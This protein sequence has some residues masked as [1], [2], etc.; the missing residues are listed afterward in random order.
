MSMTALVSAFC[1]AYHSERDGA[2]IFDDT[3]AAK[4]LT[5]EERRQIG[6]HM[7]AGV[8]F[9]DPDFRGN[10]EQALERVMDGFL[11]PAP[12][13]R[14]AFAE[15][16]FDAGSAAQYLLL[17]AGYDTFPCR[18]RAW[19]AQHGVFELDR[20]EVLADKQ[21]RMQRAGIVLP[22]SVRYA[23]ADLA[24]PS[25]PDTLRQAGFSPEKPT[26]CAAM[27]LSYYLTAETMARLLEALSSL[28]AA[29][30]EVALDV[31]T[32]VL[33]V[34]QA[35]AG[36]AGETMQTVY[37]WEMLEEMAADRGMQLARWLAP[38][39]VQRRYVDPYNAASGR[40]PMAAPANVAL[41]LLVK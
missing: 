6:G 41:C 30:S 3:Y 18:R 1:R 24:D 9:F 25:W 15:E 33:Q 20:D 12:L 27:G 14:A 10:A 22:D 39:D 21:R 36:A 32:G 16:C 4:L 23:A 28:L 26:F 11:S 17:G 5:A 40:V 31:P 37:R 19:A 34:Q 38:E 35:L 8:S 2:K 13:C 29:G 7:A